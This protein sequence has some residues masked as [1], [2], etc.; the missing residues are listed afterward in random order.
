MLYGR[1][2]PPTR[3]LARCKSFAP[4]FLKC[5]VGRI[6]II[7]L[8]GK[9][10]RRRTMLAFDTS[11]A[12]ARPPGSRWPRIPQET[13]ETDATRKESAEFQNHYG[14]FLLPQREAPR[15]TASVGGPPFFILDTS[16]SS[17]FS[18]PCIVEVEACRDNSANLR[19]CRS[20]P[21]PNFI[22]RES[23]LAYEGCLAN[24]Y[25]GGIRYS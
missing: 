23:Y 21:T 11:R 3:S 25:D 4:V 6:V 18:A 2:R 7:A 19:H 20:V 24:P 9:W 22:Y 12:P 17:N 5:S 8:F 15:A 14:L 10:G 13:S 1:V 16:N